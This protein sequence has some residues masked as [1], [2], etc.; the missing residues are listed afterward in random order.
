MDAQE[1]FCANTCRFFCGNKV[2]CIV[3]KSLKAL[4]GV[5]TGGATRLPHEWC[6]GGHFGDDQQRSNSGEGREPAQGGIE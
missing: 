3:I 4:L 5:S 6:G 2:Y 1:Q